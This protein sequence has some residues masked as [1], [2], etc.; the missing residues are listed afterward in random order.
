MDET[1]D[2]P[3]GEELAP[4][5]MDVLTVTATVNALHPQTTASLNTAQSILP[6]ASYV[7]L[8]SATGHQTTSV[9][10]S[11]PVVYLSSSANQQKVLSTI[12]PV[13]VLSN[14][15]GKGA[16]EANVMLENS[17][18][19]FLRLSG[20][21]QN[22]QAMAQANLIAQ[23]QE[24]IAQQ[25]GEEEM[26]LQSK[27]KDEGDTFTS[28]QSSCEDEE[29]TGHRQGKSKASGGKV[30]MCETEGCGKTF[31]SAGFRKFHQTAQ[32][33]SVSSKA[34]QCPFDQCGR[35]FA[36]PAHFK[37][38]QLTHTDN[39]QYECELEGCGKR[40][41]TAQRLKVHM[42]THTG[43]KPFVCTE[44]N[45][46]FT[47]AGNLKNHER[48]HSGERPYAC[49]Y[50]GCVRKFT[51]CSSLKKHKLVHT[52]EKP[53][54][55]NICFKT[56]S[57]SGSRKVHMKR[58]EMAAAATAAVTMRRER[59]DIAVTVTSSSAS[60]IAVKREINEEGMKEGT[61]NQKLIVI[62]ELAQHYGADAH[63][64]VVLTQG[65]TDHVVTV[66]TQPADSDAEKI[67]LPDNILEA[68][69]LHGDPIHT[70]ALQAGDKGMNVVV[71]SQPQEIVSLTSPYH[72]PH[73]PGRE[74]IIYETDLL[75]TDLDH[76]EIA[77][78]EF[79]L[80][81]LTQGSQ[82]SGDMGDGIM[83]A[84]QGLTEH[85]DISSSSQTGREMAMDPM[86]ESD[87]DTDH[88]EDL[89]TN[90]QQTDKV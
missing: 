17:S 2:S 3:S 67:H 30:Y 50:E 26:A 66:T 25:L 70:E 60:A 35:K 9:D 38:H 69:G 19:A 34:L 1:V 37:Y 54:S 23:T 59:N 71:L 62:H 14:N 39:R 63:E 29:Q 42:R 36:R 21:L 24:H 87:D 76:E 49:D 48:I 44:C 88:V 75:H 86:M 13:L 74:E 5:K 20:D 11:Q 73:I 83:A 58:H 28:L 52:G 31:A 72:Q 15:H 7:Y 90:K 77:H 61:D 16:M 84:D 46:S 56:F 81:S 33:H 10:N 40:F 43:E 55:C 41:F 32:G 6:Q 82:G 8:G 22:I 78:S 89:V 18:P 4:G 51:E 68:Q 27:V 57:Q 79:S 85:G 80:Q 53:F 65:L 47:T 12:T 45:K 64:P